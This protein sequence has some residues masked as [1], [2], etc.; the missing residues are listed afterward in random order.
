MCS[1]LSITNLVAE[2]VDCHRFE[3]Q[4]GKKAGRK[5]AGAWASVSDRLMKVLA[6]HCTGFEM[7]AEG[8]AV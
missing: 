4:P 7:R 6:P 5:V 8:E 1:Q 3:G 2:A